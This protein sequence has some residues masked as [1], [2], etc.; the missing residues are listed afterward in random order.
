MKRLSLFLGILLSALPSSSWSAGELSRIPD[1]GWY[2]RSLSKLVY[3]YNY[4]K[5]F[6]KNYEE[7]ERGS[8]CQED[9]LSWE[10]IAILAS[11]RFSQPWTAEQTQNFFN[12]RCREFY[13][14]VFESQEEDQ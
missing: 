5:T 13:K 10:I 8:Y 14:R 11:N 2:V 7:I 3:N 6:I 9:G 1:E 12:T 4:Y